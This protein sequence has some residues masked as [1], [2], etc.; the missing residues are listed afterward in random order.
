MQIYRYYDVALDSRAIRVSMRN[1]HGDEFYAI[2]AVDRSGAQLRAKRR[3]AIHA[4][5][6]A[7]RSGRDP[8]AVPVPEEEE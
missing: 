3:R 7:I 8:G 5:E 2:V 6:T 1:A 4:I